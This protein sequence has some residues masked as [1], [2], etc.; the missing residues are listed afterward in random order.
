[1]LIEPGA[2]VHMIAICGTAMGSLAGMLRQRGFRITGS[3]AHAYPPMS[4][5]LRD[6]GI[7]VKEGFAAENVRHSDLVVVGNAVSRG[8]PEVE[9][10]L[11]RR[12]PYLSLPEVLREVFLRGRR[13]V[14][15]SGTHGKTTTTA[16]TAYLL[17][18][19]GLDPSF[20][21]AGLPG[22]FD[23]S[24]HLG[25]GEHFVI[26]GDE[27]DSAYFFKLPKFF[28]YLPE[29]LVINNIEFD[30]ADIYATLGEIEKVFRQLINIVPGNGLILANQ[31]DPVL[32]PLLSGSF[33]PVQTFGM[34]A[35]AH[36]QASG[37]ESHEAG[38][39]FDVEC[40][41]Q[42]LG[43]FMVPLHGEYNVRN[44]L[45]A[46]GVG[47]QVG[48]DPD[49]LR[50]AL[51]GF[52]GVQRRQQRLGCV[53][54]VTIIDD[55]AHHPTAVAA[56][57]AGLRGAYRAARFHVLFEPA[58]ATNA[59]AVF[60]EQYVTAF[61]DAHQVIIGRVPRPERARGDPPFDGERLAAS[62]RAAGQSA[63]Y[64]PAVDWMME[65]LRATVA[66]GDVVVVMSNS[67]FGGVQQRLLE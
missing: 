14:V 15:I 51:P 55:F 58:S 66:P 2:H 25:Q 19:G 1:M 45:A 41:G 34:S 27:Y 17:S 28:F 65:R 9:E 49:S 31:E 53:G 13:P 57:L 32:R 48:M 20:L 54:G 61:R 35:H 44:C 46:I 23:R 33:A 42:S 11:A 39:S 52:L 40:G 8:N 16:L 50:R 63:S 59:R 7:E 67:G 24:Y 37:L 56:T 62:L 30:H 36:L 22:N 64:L 10:M 60:E 38:T 4:T 26:E 47:L 12:I 6:L 43:R 21:V 18:Q 5:L 29:I 3:D